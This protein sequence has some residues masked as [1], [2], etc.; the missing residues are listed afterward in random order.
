MNNR[1]L[2]IANPSSGKGHIQKV[3][4]DIEQSLLRINILFSMRQRSKSREATPIVRQAI[5]TEG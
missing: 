5:D 3:W 2:I 4:V 1:W